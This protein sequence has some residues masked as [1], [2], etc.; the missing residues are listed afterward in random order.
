[1]SS[2]YVNPSAEI[3]PLVVFEN[4]SILEYERLLRSHT[5]DD[6][7][8]NCMSIDDFQLMCQELVSSIEI[9]CSS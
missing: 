8:V 9:I 5:A 6:L 1:M 7:S 3:V 4:V 2:K